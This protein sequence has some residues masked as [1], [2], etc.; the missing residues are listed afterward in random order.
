MRTKKFSISKAIK[1]ISKQ[2]QFN[3]TYEKIKKGRSIDSIQFHISK[4][5]QLKD[6]NGEYK[7]REQE[8]VYL[9]DK[10]SKED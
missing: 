7:E 4:K 2:T 5:A 9:Q 6:V 1:E 8:P 3:V 10:A